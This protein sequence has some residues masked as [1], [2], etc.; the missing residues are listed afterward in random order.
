V[1]Q[2][3]TPEPIVVDLADQA[4]ETEL[5]DLFSA[6]FGYRMPAELWRWKYQGLD[7]LGAVLRHQGRLAAFYGAMPRAVHLFGNPVMAVQIGDVMVRPEARATLTRKGPF[8]QVA[9]SFL[10]S[11]IGEGKTYPIAFGFPAERTYRLAAHLGLY[12]KVGELLSVSWPALPARPSYTVRMRP[13][14]DDNRSIVDRLWREM[15]AALTE[16][17][18]GVRDWPYLQRRYVQHPTVAY[19]LY[20]VSSRLTGTPI[21]IVVIRVLDDAVEL[22]DIIAPPQRLATLV[23]CVRRLTWNLKKPLVYVWITAQNATLLAGD[24]GQISSTDIIIPHNNWTPGLSAN[25]LLDRWW[26][27]GGDTDFR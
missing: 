5:L 9:A 27:M 25:E 3:K 11:F 23:H 18:V 10:E 4:S 19:Q 13:L 26:L 12:E 17:V 1:L 8:F 21:G 2:K 15:A 22:L 16:Q 20:L 14:G 7:T 6:A 24:S